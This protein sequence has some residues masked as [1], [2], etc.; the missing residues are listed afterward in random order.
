MKTENK[1]P[2]QKEWSSGL[3]SAAV[4]DRVCIAF[5]QRLQEG[6]AAVALAVCSSLQSPLQSL[7]HSLSL[8]SLK[9]AE[10]TDRGTRR[11]ATEAERSM[12]LLSTRLE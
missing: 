7:S 11:E 8:H 5:G 4:C 3:P 2:C 1:L 9:A 12:L 10:A 6:A